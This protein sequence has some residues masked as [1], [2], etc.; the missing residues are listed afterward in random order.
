M[1]ALRDRATAAKAGV[2]LV[3]VIRTNGVS[4]VERGSGWVARCPFHEEETGS[5][6]VNEAKG[7]FHCFGCGASGDAIKFIELARG[8]PFEEAVRILEQQR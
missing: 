8:V 6:H 2:S 4:L 5:F 1:R 7:F 3:R